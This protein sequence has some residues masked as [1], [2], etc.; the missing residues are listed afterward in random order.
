MKK[1]LFA[2]VLVALP[3]SM[4]GCGG[5]TG[6]KVVEGEMEAGQESITSSQMSEYEAAMKSGEGSSAPG[7]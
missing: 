2:I 1:M 6:N 5:P 3:C 7:N 4:I